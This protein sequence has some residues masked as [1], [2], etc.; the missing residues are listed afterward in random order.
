[1]LF[2][3]GSTRNLVVPV[4]IYQPLLAATTNAGTI[5]DASFGTPIFNLQ[6]SLY[7]QKVRVQNNTPFPFTALRLT[8]TNLPA[9]VTLQN[10]TLTNGG[11]AYIDYNTSVPA[12]SNVTLKLEYF[13]SDL[14]PFTPGLKLELLGA[15][16]SITAPDGAVM[17]D[18]GAKTGYSPDGA[19]KNYLYFPSTAGQ[20]YYVQYLDD[21]S[22]DWQT[23]PV[24]LTGTGQL[25]NWMDD[26]PPSTATPPGPLRFYRVV[27]DR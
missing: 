17:T 5:Y 9:T 23:S 13:S 16:R 18:V 6:T 21:I 7:E 15:A 8:A 22:G 24:V 3:D 11:L 4:T 2:N 12:G 14:K 27:T 20:R 10:A 19:R 25:M 26:G 1:V